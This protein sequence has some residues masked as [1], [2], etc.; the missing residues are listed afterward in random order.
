MIKLTQYIDLFFSS[1]FKKKFTAVISIPLIITS[2]YLV[3]FYLLPEL[4]ETDNIEKI[5][6]ITAPQSVVGTSAR[7]NK[8]IGKKYVTENG[9]NFSISN[10][11]SIGF[12]R[13]DLAIS[14]I[15]KRV[16]KVSLKN[17][18]IRISSGMNGMSKY[19]FIICYSIIIGSIC[20]ILFSKNITENAKL[21]LIYFNVF[22]F[23]LWGWIIF[24]FGI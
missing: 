13:V 18:Q 24:N 22:M 19:I 3:D 12:N 14:P 23:C 20:Y 15:F 5:Y 11:S 10:K 2:L 7:R 8:K 21:N 4:K 1:K 16:K 6:T 17:K 9:F